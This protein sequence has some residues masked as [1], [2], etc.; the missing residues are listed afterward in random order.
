MKFGDFVAGA[1][2]VSVLELMAL[3]VIALVLLSGFRV[4]RRMVAHRPMPAE[5][6]ERWRRLEPVLETVAWLLYLVSAVAWLLNGHPGL[7]LLALG[8]LGVGLV[9]AAWFVIRDYL[10]GLVLRA[11]G[12][13]RLGDRVQIGDLDGTV[14]RLGARSLDLELAGGERVVLGYRAARDAVIV[15][16]QGLRLATAARFRVALSDGTSLAAAHRA[17]R[18]AVLLQPWVPGAAEPRLDDVDGGIEVTV[19]V[20]GAGRDAEVAAAVRLASDA[21][22]RP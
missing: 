4:L 6:R 20:L 15:R 1:P 5:R 2:T 9:A 16:Q 14:R 13:L 17:I 3:L 18:R 8:L 19:P 22:P 21:H 7:R 11:E 10:D 12:A